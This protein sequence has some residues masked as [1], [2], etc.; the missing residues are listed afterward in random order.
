LTGHDRPA[1]LLRQ[2]AMPHLGL[3]RMDN[4]HSNDT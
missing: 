2:K 4:L 1:S 3:P